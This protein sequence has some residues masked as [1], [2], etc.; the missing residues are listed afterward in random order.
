MEITL[1]KTVRLRK[2]H[3]LLSASNINREMK[4]RSR[5]NLTW[6]FLFDSI[7]ISRNSCPR[8]LF[9]ISKLFLLYV[10]KLN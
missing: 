10:H 4:M 9:S 8:E 2:F 1:D 6:V 7:S 3:N 5:N